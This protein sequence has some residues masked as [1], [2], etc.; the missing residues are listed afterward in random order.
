MV[1]D[2]GGGIVELLSYQIRRLSPFELGELVIPSGKRYT[3]LF[4]NNVVTD[5]RF[6]THHRL[7][8]VEKKIRGVG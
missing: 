6:R 4:R 3:S 7:P 2:A 1:C 5:L 8:H